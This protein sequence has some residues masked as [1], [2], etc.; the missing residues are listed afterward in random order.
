MAIFG[1]AV[2]KSDGQPLKMAPPSKI[3]TDFLKPIF[4]LPKKLKLPKS[5]DFLR[6]SAIHK[7]QYTDVVMFGFLRHQKSLTG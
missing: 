1:G 7:D 4:K 6:V 2:K 3:V 5:P